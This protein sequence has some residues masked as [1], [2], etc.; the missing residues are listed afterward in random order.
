LLVFAEPGPALAATLAL[1]VALAR[2]LTPY[3]L[4]AGFG[5]HSGPVVE[6]M[7]GSSSVKAFD[8]LGDTVNVAKRLC[9]NAGGGEILVSVATPLGSLAAGGTRELVLKGKAQPLTVRILVAADAP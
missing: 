8:V 5:V 4:S 2:H 1:R 6:G 7:L 9:D 3:C